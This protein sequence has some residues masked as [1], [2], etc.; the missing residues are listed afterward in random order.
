MS[1]LNIYQRINA[2]MKEVTY[3]QKDREVS[4]GGQ[5]YKAVTH[6]QV[7]SVARAALV[8]HG[9][10]VYPEQSAG[11]MLVMRDPS[12]DVKMHLYTGSYAV[13]FVNIDKPEDRMT[14][15]VQAHAN[16]NG[17]K[18]PGKAIT[19]ATKAAILK[20]LLLET[21]ENDEGRSQAGSMDVDAAL[22]EIDAINDLTELRE[23]YKALAALCVKNKDQESWKQLKPA[24]EVRAKELA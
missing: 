8:K 18:S 7:V 11:E 24:L 13:H 22:L 14:V 1:E 5:N 12:K 2:V 16:D 15:L 9:I 19:Y 23:K 6:D 3:V 4:G 10:V 21:G 20:A 17:D